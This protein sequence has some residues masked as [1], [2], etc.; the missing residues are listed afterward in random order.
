MRGRGTHTIPYACME[1]CRIEEAERACDVCVRISGEAVRVDVE[2]VEYT[3][4]KA[5]PINRYY[6]DGNVGCMRPVV[7]RTH[8]CHVAS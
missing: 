2:G 6:V 7:W 4:K 3:G 1:R 8:G 5:R